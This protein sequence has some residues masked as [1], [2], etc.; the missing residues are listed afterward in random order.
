[1]DAAWHSTNVPVTMAGLERAV[2]FPTVQ[3]SISAPGK[4]SVLQ[5]TCV[6]VT[7]DF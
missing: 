4:E 5:V 7:R 3:L 6:A 1:M 2:R